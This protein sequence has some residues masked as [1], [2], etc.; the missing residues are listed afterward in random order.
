MH[1]SLTQTSEIF[2]YCAPPGRLTPPPLITGVRLGRHCSLDLA[3]DCKIFPFT[4]LPPEV[5]QLV[6]AECLVVGKVFPYTVSERYHEYDNDDDEQDT[7]LELSDCEVPSVALLQ[8]CKMIHEE[9][10]PMLYQRNIFVLP[11]CDL[12]ILFFKRSLHND[13]RKSWVKSVE[14]DFVAA[15]LTRKDRELVLDAQIA[16]ARNDLLFPEKCNAGA[17]FA[18]DLHEAYIERLVDVVW[19]RK[20]S[21]VGNHLALR[22][23]HLKFGLSECN[24]GC[25]LLPG[26]AIQAMKGGFARGMPV[27]VKITGLGKA[28]EPYRKVM[29]K[30][31][32]MRKLED[33]PY[34]HLLGLA[35]IYQ[36][37]PEFDR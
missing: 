17:E 36:K 18:H 32:S 26:A 22:K 4:S 20:A 10:E 21:Y 35:Q 33:N 14:L 3:N 34:D 31:T 28:R 19:P 9:A 29:A 13:V 24:E 5:R 8:V 7:G 23:I 30:W 12:T 25:C 16:L 1:G 15:D 11:A 27:E 6:Y 2:L 37:V